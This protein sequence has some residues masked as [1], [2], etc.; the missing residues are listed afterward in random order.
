MGQSASVDGFPLGTTIRRWTRNLLS[1]ADPIVQIYGR[2]APPL[3]LQVSRA[4]PNLD[5]AERRHI[6]DTLEA[7]RHELSNSISQIEAAMAQLAARE[8]SLTA[9]LSHVEQERAIYADALS[10]YEQRWKGREEE[11]GAQAA[12][13]GQGGTEAEEEKA[14]KLRHAL[15][16]TLPGLHSEVHRQLVVMREDQRRLSDKLEGL[17]GGRSELT[18]NIDVVRDAEEVNDADDMDRAEG[19]AG[20]DKQRAAPPAAGSGGA[21]ATAI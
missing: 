2:F 9:Q 13:G 17:R 15:D 19:A 3:S 21:A 1:L 16:V 5:Q 12:E 8:K 10:R 6:I 18:N 11:G 20:A 7:D 4:A 14:A